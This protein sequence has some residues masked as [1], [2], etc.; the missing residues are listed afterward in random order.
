MINI[1]QKD[2]K[3][4]FSGGS[5]TFTGNPAGDIHSML[6]RAPC[7]MT[8]SLALFV[9]FVWLTLFV[10][11]ILRNLRTDSPRECIFRA[12]ESRFWNIYH[13]NPTK[14]VL[15]WVQF[16]YWST[17]TSLGYFPIYLLSQLKD[18][19]RMRTIYRSFLFWKLILLFSL[20]SPVV[21]LAGKVHGNKH[22]NLM[23]LSS[24]TQKNI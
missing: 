9:L 5:E 20:S 14:V 21:I 8:Q 22:F 2:I 10:T 6:P 11:A 3:I 19:V 17:C 24:I 15:S 7:C 23:K 18:A 16:M 4:W 1:T 12:C 13:L